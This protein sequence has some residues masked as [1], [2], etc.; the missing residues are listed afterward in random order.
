M[1]ESD[2]K[3]QLSGTELKG[4]K[5][6]RT[7]RPWVALLALV[8][9]TVVIS[10]MIA[11]LL[12][13]YPKRVILKANEM[14]DVTDLKGHWEQTSLHCFE[15]DSSPPF[16]SQQAANSIIYFYNETSHLA[17]A[18]TLAEMKSS[19]QANG[20]YGEW[21]GTWSGAGESV[22]ALEIGDEGMLNGHLS[23][24]GTS[25]GSALSALPKGRLCRGDVL[26]R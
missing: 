5:R 13:P 17:I 2:E 1:S 23:P 20:T 7:R 18:I 21:N 14:G 26:Q 12:D 22:A 24:D 4:E 15:D 9:L 25:D 16:S 19:E 8:V 10:A 11:G 3:D 6:K